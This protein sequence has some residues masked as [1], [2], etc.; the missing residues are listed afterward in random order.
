MS[1]LEAAPTK[2]EKGEQ[3]AAHAS[4]D[5]AL[6]PPVSA[7]DNHH[8]IE[9]RP[10]AVVP[11]FG[12]TPTFYDSKDSEAPKKGLHP[13]GALSPEGPPAKLFDGLG[14]NQQRVENGVIYA[15]Q[16]D[17]D[18]TQRRIIRDPK[19]NTRIEDVSHP[20]GSTELINSQTDF[21]EAKAF[22]ADG[23][24]R[25]YGLID[26]TRPAPDGKD[27]EKNIVVN[28]EYDHGKLI[29]DN[30]RWQDKSGDWHENNWMKMSDNSTY[31]VVM[32]GDV[33]A[34]TRVKANGS[35]ENDVQ[36]AN[37]FDPVTG[38]RKMTFKHTESP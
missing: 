32:D 16:Q 37:A 7:S 36:T 28:R 31:Q 34:K 25:S 9:A 19:A 10:K 4:G 1:K 26:N 35:W 14:P 38:R 13:Q 3:I 20:D 15:R 22:D 23:K 30:N 33:T 18:G 6:A 21:R 27:K 8:L 5:K 24:V 29:E 11:E 17:E 2:S 12:S